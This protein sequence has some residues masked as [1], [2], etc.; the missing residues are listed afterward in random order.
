MKCKDYEELY[1]RDFANRQRAMCAGF[2]SL[3]ACSICF[4]QNELLPAGRA[5]IGGFSLICASAAMVMAFNLAAAWLCEASHCLA[6]AGEIERARPAANFP[7]PGF[8]VSRTGSTPVW[9]NGQTSCASVREIRGYNM[10]NNSR[11]R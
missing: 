11:S 2:L 6:V 9:G 1:A 4:I 3:L 7:G 10:S 8:I 5:A